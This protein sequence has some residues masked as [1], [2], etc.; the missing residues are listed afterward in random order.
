M[1]ISWWYSS[2][3]IIWLHSVK[4]SRRLFC[5]VISLVFSLSLSRPL[6]MILAWIIRIIAAKSLPR[7]N[8][9]IMIR[10]IYH[11]YPSRQDNDSWTFITS[12]SPW[13]AVLTEHT[14]ASKMARPRVSSL[15]LLQYCAEAVR[16]FDSCRHLFPVALSLWCLS[17]MIYFIHY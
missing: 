13:C 16:L 14:K 15:I 12:A 17:S 2:S 5:S 11:E 9:R 10:R 8:A 7:Y 4:S 3:Q 1:H 6:L